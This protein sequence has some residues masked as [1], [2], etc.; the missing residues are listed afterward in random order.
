[1]QILLTC[2]GVALV[3]SIVVDVLWT[4]IAV[5]GGGGPITSRVSNCLW[6]LLLH[7]HRSSPSHQMLSV[8]GYSTI[9]IS[10]LLWILATW[11]G[12]VLIFS[13]SDRS[14]I[15]ADTKQ[16]AD[17]WERIYFTGYTLV[18]LGLGDYQ[19]QGKIWQ[20]ATATAAANGFFLITLSITY[21]LSVVSAGTQKRQLA[22]YISSLGYTPT[23]I[24][25]K[26]WNGKDFGMLSQHLVAIAPMLALYGQSHFAYPVLHYFHSTRRETAAEVNMAV[27]D[28]ALTLLEFGIKPE[29]RPDSVALYPVRQ[30]LSVFLETL[31]SAYIKPASDVP[32]LAVLDE[33]RAYGIP[34]VS[35]EAFASEVSNLT[36]RRRLLLAL[37]RNDGWSWKEVGNRFG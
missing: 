13:T 31:T 21:L 8:A 27:L 33:L 22:T 11:A 18:T 32:P 9:G 16:P 37:V 3:V 19:P 24:V 5:G 25:T 14:L 6:K 12:W 15:S 23:E 36:K 29:H 10:T 20:L 1:M 7:R 17:I 30:T 34:T 26:A 4:T 35:D 28:E 2:L